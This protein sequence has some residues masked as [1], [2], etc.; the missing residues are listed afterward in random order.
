MGRVSLTINLEEMPLYDANKFWGS[1]T[2]SSYE[3]FKILCV[4]GGVPRYLEEI[5]P[6]QTAEQNYSNPV[7]LLEIMSGMEVSK[8]SNFINTDSRTIISAFTS[9][10]LNRKSN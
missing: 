9:T 6:E 2:I 7:F 10:I 8:E 5:Q 3:K 4:T 1:R